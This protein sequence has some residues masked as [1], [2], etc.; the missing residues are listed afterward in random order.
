MEMRSE[1]TRCVG[2]FQLEIKYINVG[3]KDF[4]QQ[5]T[6]WRSLGKWSP[7]SR[8]IN[9]SASSKQSPKLKPFKTMAVKTIVRVLKKK[10]VSNIR[11]LWTWQWNL[12]YYFFFFLAI[13]GPCLGVRLPCPI[14][15]CRQ[16][17]KPRQRLWLWRAPSWGS[18]LLYFHSSLIYKY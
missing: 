12:D 11:G 7:S 15:L 5:F 17:W 10:L 13:V 9:S 4:R 14:G 1:L 6:V 16:Q 3:S 18:W 8:T 2:G